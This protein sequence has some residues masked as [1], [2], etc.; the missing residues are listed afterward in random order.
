VKIVLGLC[1]RFSALPSQVL[2]ESADVLRMTHVE[3]LAGLRQQ[4]GEEDPGA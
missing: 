3:Q 1:D 4:G 2:G